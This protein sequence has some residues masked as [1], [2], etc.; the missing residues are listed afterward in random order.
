[1]VQTTFVH[2]QS[3]EVTSRNKLLIDVSED[4]SMIRLLSSFG[5]LMRSEVRVLACSKLPGDDDDGK[6]SWYKIG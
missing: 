2:N 1:M 3:P 5:I 6:V 4:Q